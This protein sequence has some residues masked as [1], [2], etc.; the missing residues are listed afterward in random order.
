MK[1]NNTVVSPVVDIKIDTQNF[2]HVTPKPVYE[3]LKR[4]FDIVVSIL[5]I[6]ILFVP[7]LILSFLILIES[8]GAPAIYSHKRVGKDGKVFKLYK[9]S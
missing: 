5:G 1:S 6:I 7:L 2:V 9:F 3:F 4:G 8:P